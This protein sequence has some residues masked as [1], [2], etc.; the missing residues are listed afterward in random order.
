M[1]RAARDAF[2]GFTLLLWPFLTDGI[3]RALTVAGSSMTG[4]GLPGPT[5]TVPP[6]I[7]FAP[8]PPAW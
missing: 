1:G 7:Q 4:V 8:Q 3:T 2:I 5:G 6:V